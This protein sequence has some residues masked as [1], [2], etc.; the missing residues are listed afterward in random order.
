MQKRKKYI[1]FSLN[2]RIP[3]LTNQNEN[4]KIHTDKQKKCNK[5]YRIAI[6]KHKGINM[7]KNEN[8][9]STENYSK[10]S[11]F[12]GANF[13]IQLYYKTGKKYHCTRSKVEKLLSIAGFVVMAKKSASLYNEDIVVNSCGTGF[14]E[15]PGCFPPDIIEGTEDETNEK[16]NEDLSTLLDESQGVAIPLS[17]K[18]ISAPLEEHTK[19]LLSNIFI[20]FG[21]YGSD[22]LGKAIDKFKG[23]ASK[24][25]DSGQMIIDATKV[26]DLFKSSDIITDNVDKNEDSTSNIDHLYAQIV[27]ETTSSDE[28]KSLENEGITDESIKEI[29]SKIR[30]MFIAGEAIIDKT[31]NDILDYIKEEVN[32]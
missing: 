12:D 5:N 11:A 4:D 22:K 26:Y 2:I 14:A 19:Q 28:K 27:S 31:Y 18:E 8:M 20:R 30:E 16:I 15:F 9:L 7:D 32:K 24:V 23:K 17:Y 10:I 3:L 1:E 21:N 29:F 6:K 25:S 13:I